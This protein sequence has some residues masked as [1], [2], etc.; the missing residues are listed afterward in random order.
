[1]WALQN[2]MEDQKETE[3]Q[4][5]KNPMAKSEQDRLPSEP[6]LQAAPGFGVNSPNGW[7]NL[8]LKDPRSEWWELK[9]QWKEEWKNGKTAVS[10]DGKTKT[11]MTL[12]I[13]KA[14]EEVLKENLKAR[15]GSEAEKALNEASTFVSDSSAGRMRSDRR[16]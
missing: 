4:A 6:R 15:T 5:S 12:P 7:V 2:V 1:M 14:K 9:K 16:R 3:D 11:V 8:E 10:E 13:D